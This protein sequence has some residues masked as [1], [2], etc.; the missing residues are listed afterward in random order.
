MI[1]VLDIFTY[2][3]HEEKDI[4]GPPLWG[5]C[6]TDK[7]SKVCDNIRNYKLLLVAQI[8]HVQFGIQTRMDDSSY[9]SMFS[10]NMNLIRKEIN[11]NKIRI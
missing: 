9:S 8:V 6:T 5:K 1:W 3:V 11:S 2:L 7:A 10:E 4:T